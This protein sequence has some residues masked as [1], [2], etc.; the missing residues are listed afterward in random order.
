MKFESCFADVNNVR[1][2]YVTVG[3][4]PLILFVHG[5]PEFWGE[6][7]EQLIEFSNDYQ[8]VALDMR[9][10]NLSS[11]PADTKDYAIG[12]LVQDLKALVEHLGHQRMILVAHDWGGA[13]A[14]SFANS[15]PEM[16]ESLVII[17]SPH[18][19]IFARELL[20]NKEQ[21]AASD[22]M[23]AFRTSDAETVLSENSYAKLVEAVFT[24]GSRWEFTEEVRKKYI[25]AWD[26]PGALTGGLNYYRAS[27]LY[28]PASK[29][30]RA[31]IQG[32][33]DL[34]R[35][36]FSVSVPTLVIWGE[37]DTALL[38]ALLDGLDQY[39]KNL[40]IKRIPDGSHWVVHEQPENVSNLIREFL[41]Q[42]MT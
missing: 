38:P 5:F 1:L 34:P 14:W 28:P 35:E 9:G 7:E 6:W 11:K 36:I 37:A 12:E 2:H 24:F 13:V 15:H 32:I 10:Y 33:A 22:Y 40:T 39:V 27:P 4:G 16:L 17:N 19:G 8:A 42:N 26:Q 41:A 29:A 31:R 25:A 20:H 21:Q 30:D 3:Q 23:L 18:P